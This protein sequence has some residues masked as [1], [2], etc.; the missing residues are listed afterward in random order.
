MNALIFGV[1][2]GAHYFRATG[3]Y[4]IATLLRQQGVDTEVVDF[5]D[6]WTDEEIN[7]I[8]KKRVTNQTLLIGFSIL[9]ADPSCIARIKKL[10]TQIKKEYPLVKTILGGQHAYTYTSIPCNYIVSGF[11]D[12][13]IAAIIQHIKDSNYKLK[14]RITGAGAKVLMANLDYPAFP[15]QNLGIEYTANDYILPEEQL[16]VELGR[17][18]RFNCDY[19]TFPVLGVKGDYSRSADD[20]RH[21]L[22]YMHSEFGV[23]TFILGDETVNDSTEKLQKFAGAVNKLTFD[24]WFQ[25]YI[26]ADLL[27]SRP[28]DLPLLEDMRLLGHAYGIESFNQLT[29]RCVKKGMNVER[30]KQGLLDIKNFFSKTNKYKAEYNFIIGLPM[31]SIDS[32]RNSM[33][34]GLENLSEHLLMFRELMISDE[35]SAISKDPS[36]YGYKILHDV[37]A[38][39]NTI[40]KKYWKNQEMS[41]TDAIKLRQEWEQMYYPLKTLSGWYV[42]S[43]KILYPELSL[44]E[45]LHKRMSDLDLSVSRYREKLYK[46]YISKKLS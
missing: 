15:L 29:A 5:F 11:G 21:Q 31:E 10:V 44:Q 25:G 18:C 30:V 6:M 1:S 7:E 8:L 4:R 27:I 13:A 2:N 35:I 26:R 22:E 12:I 16:T 17:G 19:C 43:I 14:Y 45:I 32:I 42:G 20:F 3:S 36:K 34:W 41:L 33:I 38:E 46:E 40:I 39:D 9:F 28:Q 24:P 23:S 37:I